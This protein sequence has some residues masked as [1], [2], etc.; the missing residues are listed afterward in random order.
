MRAGRDDRRKRRALRPA[1]T[2]RLLE[3]P[4]EVPFG[5]SGQ[6][7]PERLLERRGGQLGSLADPLELTRLLDLS[8]PLDEAARS[9][10][11]DALPRL[12]AQPP[13]G[14]DG[15]MGIVEA[16][17]PTQVLG[18]VARQLPAWET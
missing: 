3:L 2:Q 1:L 6:T 8:Q 10:E 18:Q 9:D 13:V 14:P 7:V 16:G 12:F 4:R 5:P 17:P 15:Q 11:L